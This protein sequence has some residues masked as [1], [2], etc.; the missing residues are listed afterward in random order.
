MLGCSFRS[1]W[2]STWVCVNWFNAPGRANPG[3]KMLTLVASALAG[4]D[5][6]DCCAPGE[7]PRPWAVVKAPST[8][9]TSFRWGHVEP[10]AAGPGLRAPIRDIRSLATTAQRGALETGDVLMARQTP[11]GAPPIPFTT[12]ASTP[13]P[14][15][16]PLLHHHPP[17]INTRAGLAIPYWMEGAADV[18]ETSK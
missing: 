14:S 1:R 13:T 15:R 17:L 11:L 7:P 3:D 12:A 9:G 2:P 5:C 4:G 10:G 8:L 6:I 18:A 16:C